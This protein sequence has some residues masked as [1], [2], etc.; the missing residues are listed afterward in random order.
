M[1]FYEIITD[2]ACAQKRNNDKRYAILIFLM[3]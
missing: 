3:K 2:E 1:K